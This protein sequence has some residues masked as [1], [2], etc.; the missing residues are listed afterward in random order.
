MLEQ[1]GRG[2]SV[3]VVVVVVVVLEARFVEHK[4]KLEVVSALM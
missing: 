4:T 1:V 3:A 2:E